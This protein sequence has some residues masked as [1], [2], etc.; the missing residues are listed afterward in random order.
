MSLSCGELFLVGRI[1]RR[2]L[3]AEIPDVEIDSLVGIGYDGPIQAEPFN[4]AL[5]A[6]PMDQA[7][8]AT[9]AA[10]NKAFG[11]AGIV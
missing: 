7:C 3:N 1:L 9:A 5:R 8:A 2:F 4:A 10:I 6:M 11:I